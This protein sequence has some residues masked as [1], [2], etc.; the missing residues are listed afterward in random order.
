MGRKVN[1]R[2]VQ[3]TN[4]SCV[5]S[6]CSMASRGY[7]ID[8]FVQLFVSKN[9]RRSPLINRG[10][11]VRS[12][13]L[14]TLLDEFCH[15]FRHQ[16]CQVL[17]FGAGFDTTFFRLKS[18][19]ILPK[20]CR[21]FEVDLPLVISKKLKVISNSVT[22]TALAGAPE[23][24]GCYRSYCLLTQDICDPIALDGALLNAGLNFS[25][26]TLLLAECVLSYLSVKDSNRLIEWTARKFKDAAFAVYEQICP[27]DAFGIFMLKHFA[28]MGSPLKSLREYP[29]TESL[30]RRYVS[31]GY[32]A[33]ECVTMTNFFEQL[34]SQEQARIRALEPFD[35]FE[36][37]HQKCAHYV[38]TFS[39][40]GSAFNTFQQVF[41]LEPT[42]Q[43]SCARHLT[44]R[45]H[46]AHP[47]LRRFG[48][49]SVMTPAG[50]VLTAGGF[51]E[52]KG[53]HSRVFAPVLTDLTIF[54]STPIA[55]G[56]EGRQ[57]FAMVRLGDGSILINGGR[58]SPLQACPSDLI[59]C[60]VDSDCSFVK[61]T[62]YKSEAPHP[63]WRHSLCVL[64]PPEKG[65]KVILFGGR[66]ADVGALDDCHV[67]DIPSMKWDQV[68]GGSCVPTPRHS[69]AVVAKG[70]AQMV[71]TCG[72]SAQE[73]PLNDVH[74][75]NIETLA[76]SE[77]QVSGVLPR[78]SWG[79]SSQLLHSL[80]KERMAHNSAPSFRHRRK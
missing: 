62:S 47:S 1:H 26:P 41:G 56:L 8:E 16:P 53:K 43:R 2:S 69:H 66:T 45:L 5:I 37:W 11:Y 21:Y 19:G 33:C 59:L 29:D 10:Y 24:A 38:L 72:L 79:F 27:N 22:L 35:E 78:Y 51:A 54:E 13:C 30:R 34:D 49:A 44:W 74:S 70:Q 14:S 7:T 9:A 48:H 80:A 23:E 61:S 25:L 76:W 64:H 55:V 12:K 28:A 6:K 42:Y 68:L 3:S 52:S 17:S 39:T 75:F 31:L 58:T 20:Q 40:K 71:L 50:K 63:R 32:D 18:A 73:R 36:E 4:D 46:E 65:E 67:L 57:H 77:L 60:R 15:I